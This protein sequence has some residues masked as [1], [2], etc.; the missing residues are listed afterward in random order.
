[1]AAGDVVAKLRMAAHEE[2]TIE[3]KKQAVKDMYQARRDT[4]KRIKHLRDIIKVAQGPNATPGAAARLQEFQDELAKKVAYYKHLTT[5]EVQD[6]LNKVVE[7]IREH[8]RRVEAEAV[9]ALVVKLQKEAAEAAEKVKQDA[10][11]LA[12]A[13]TRVVRAQDAAVQADVQE[14]LAKAEEVLR[15]STSEEEDAAGAASE[16]EDEAAGSGEEDDAASG[17]E[18]QDELFVHRVTPPRGQ[19]RARDGDSTLPS[20]H[21]RVARGK[22]VV[23]L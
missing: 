5:R 4:A 9:N 1:M 21:K 8:A 20:A 13:K 6:I 11:A 3:E 17:D 22:R 2:A 12:A 23:P 14:L 18:S 7:E 10:V 15:G 16:S 19:K